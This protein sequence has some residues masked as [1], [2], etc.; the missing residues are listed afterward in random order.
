LLVWTFLNRRRTRRNG[1]SSQRCRREQDH[2]EFGECLA[3]CDHGI[4]PFVPASLRETFTTRPLAAATDEIPILK[5]WFPAAT[6][7]ENAIPIIP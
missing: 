3:R 1:I 5:S 6:M 2:F 4:E 7:H